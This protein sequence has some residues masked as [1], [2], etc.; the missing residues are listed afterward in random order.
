MEADDDARARTTNLILQ[1]NELI[2]QIFIV[3][4][5]IAC[6]VLLI[7]EHDGGRMSFVGGQ[8][9]IYLNFQF[10]YFLAEITDGLRAFHFSNA[11]HHGVFLLLREKG[12]K[13]A[14][15]RRRR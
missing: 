15:R 12:K 8:G 1:F 5:L 7:L 3:G 9:S 6:D 2:L 11:Q 10:G 14:A 4:D 13:A